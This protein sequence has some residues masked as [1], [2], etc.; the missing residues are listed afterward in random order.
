MGVPVLCSHTIVRVDGDQR[1]ETAT[2][3]TLDSN[4]KVIPGSE[5]VLEVDTVCL[6]VGL[7]PFSE[8]LSQAGCPMVFNPALGGYVPRH[9]PLL[10]TEMPGFYIAGDASGVEEASAAM[11]EGRIAGLAAAMDLRTDRGESPSDEERKRL[12]EFQ[13][14]LAS[15]RRG[16]MGS[17]AREGKNSLWAQ[18]FYT[19]EYQQLPPKE[20][21][22][23][24][25][26][27]RPVI[28]C[29]EYI[30]CDPCVSS[31]PTG[32][33]TM[34]NS[35]ND[36]PELDMAKC[37]GCGICVA[38]CP[39]LAIFLLDLHYSPTEA[40]LVVPFEMLPVPAV[41]DEV[42]ALDRDGHA[43]CKARVVSVRTRGGRL[44]RRALVG[45]AF[46]AEHASTVRHFSAHEPAEREVLEAES[47][48]DNDPIVCRCEDVRRSEVVA[49]IRDGLKSV[50]EIRRVLRV[51]MGPC[52]G[53]TC[54]TL[55]RSIL[56]AE[57]GGR[58]SDYAPSKVRAPL[59]A[60]SLG[61]LA[62]E[63]EDWELP[64]DKPHGGGH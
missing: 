14:D 6:A 41:G 60:I 25:K 62:T 32:A 31:C 26:G 38:V 36:L 29:P 37:T 35:I 28:E 8:L 44:D 16:P 7:S 55:V 42:Y 34:P 64:L 53:K 4:W 58:P 21:A 39:G 63:D 1:V 61:K 10:R 11:I 48:E 40:M 3:A 33:I 2:I 17:K 50:D 5:Q 52:Q 24:W 51:G 18:K 45:F 22:H 13:S 30:P 43:V 15:L 47:G 54:G 59:K 46:P 27:A 19:D 9:D 57:L 12:D 23:E 49:A 20:P 56:A